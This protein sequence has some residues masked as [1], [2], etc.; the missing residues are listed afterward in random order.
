M[1]K[2]A[3]KAMNRDGKEV[4]GVLESES[5]AL[6]INDIRNL[7]LFPTTVRDAR[8]SDEQG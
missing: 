4:F 7:G 3:Y 5:Q 1:A 2:F 8:K 6:A